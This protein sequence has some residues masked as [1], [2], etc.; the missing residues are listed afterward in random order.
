M[1]DQSPKH[2]LGKMSWPEVADAIDT[3]ELVLLPI[4]STE[5]HGP[6]LGLGQDHLVTQ[7]FCERAAQR[8]TPRLLAV[9]AIPWGISDHHMNIAGSMTLRP[10]TFL[11]L[12]EDLISSL[13]HHGFRR[14]LIVNGHGGNEA[15]M[16]AAVQ[17]LGFRLDIDFL[18]S[19]GH[20]QLSNPA[21]EDAIRGT[22]PTGHACEIEV[23]HACYLIPELVRTTALAAAELD[24]AFHTLQT[25]LTDLKLTWPIAIDAL[26]PSGALG[27]ARRGSYEAGERIIE[28]A[29]DELA[30][31]VDIL[32]QLPRWTGPPQSKIHMDH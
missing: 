7:A 27:D 24:H 17:D 26:T 23:S 22:T 8:L 18:G 15:L 9:P 12:L 6:N 21:H 30:E 16:T 14:F 10:E 32:R 11:D 31:I 20:Y 29:I 19:V 4:G 28:S 5:Q 1:S 3:V 13:R 25:T 2:V